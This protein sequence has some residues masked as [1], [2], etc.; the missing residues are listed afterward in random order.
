MSFKPQVLPTPS[1]PPAPSINY[2]LIYEWHAC[3]VC[4][5]SAFGKSACSSL[6]VCL[7]LEDWF[8]PTEFSFD[9]I[10]YLVTLT[11]PCLSDQQLLFL[12]F[13]AKSIVPSLSAIRISLYLFPEDTQLRCLKTLLSWKYSFASAHVWCSPYSSRISSWSPTQTNHAWSSNIFLPKLFLVGKV[14]FLPKIPIY[15]N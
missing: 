10:N 3:V 4:D 9:D 12:R 2:A 13:H 8:F 11:S 1:A 5:F 6:I 15:F 7:L 14:P